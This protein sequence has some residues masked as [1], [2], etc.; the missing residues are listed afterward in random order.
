M[1]STIKANGTVGP[2]I[3][4][5]VYES[6][7]FEADHCIKLTDDDPDLQLVRRKWRLAI[8]EAFRSLPLFEWERGAPSVHAISDD[9]KLT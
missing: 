9:I 2:P 8:G 1:D 6:G 3:E 7:T 5:L 4:I